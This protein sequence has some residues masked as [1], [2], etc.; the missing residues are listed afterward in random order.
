MTQ[1]KYQTNPSLLKTGEL[2]LVAGQLVTT[3]GTSTVVVGNPA[4]STAVS[5][6]TATFAEEVMDV[7]TVKTLGTG[8][9]FLNG[10]SFDA[11]GSSDYEF[12]EANGTVFG[13]YGRT[14]GM[15]Q[16]IYFAGASNNQQDLQFTTV[17]YVPPF[18]SSSIW[19]AAAVVGN[20][21]FGFTLALRDTTAATL[22]FRF[23]YVRHNGSLINTAGHTYVEITPLVNSYMTTVGIDAGGLPRVTR[24]GAY[25]FIAASSWTQ[26]WLALGGWNAQDATFPFGN[27]A[28]AA[29]AP[30]YA[31][32]TFTVQAVNWPNMATT[33]PALFPK[34]MG[35]A[36]PGQTAVDL[37]RLYDVTNNVLSNSIGGNWPLPPVVQWVDSTPVILDGEVDG[38][39]NPFLAFGSVGQCADANANSA[40]FELVYSLSVSFTAG[41]AGAFT[42]AQFV[43]NTPGS[44]GTD[45]LHCQPF[46]FI[47]S[48]SPD[49][50][51]PNETVASNAAVPSTCVN[52]LP[53]IQHW[54]GNDSAN[55]YNSTRVVNYYYSGFGSV[56]HVGGTSLYRGR[57]QIMTG[58]HLGSAAAAQANKLAHIYPMY[59]VVPRYDFSSAGAL[60]SKA[61]VQP[62]G[63]LTAIEGGMIVAADTIVT[64]GVDTLGN[65]RWVVSKLPTNSTLGDRTYN[66]GGSAVPGMGPRVAEYY[67]NN[68]TLIG[69][70]LNT[71]YNV[72]P[73]GI[74]NIRNPLNAK[75]PALASSS[76]NSPNPNGVTMGIGNWTLSGSTYNEPNTTQWTTSPSMSSQ[77]AAVRATAFT[78]ALAFNAGRFGTLLSCEVVPLLNSAGTGVSMA[79]GVIWVANG[80][81]AAATSLQEFIFTTPCSMVG[82]VI[83]LTNTASVTMFAQATQSGLPGIPGTTP[84]SDSFFGRVHHV[85]IDATN[86]YLLW[87]TANGVSVNG[88]T[89]ACNTIAKLSGTTVTSAQAFITSISRAFF[90]CH[91]QTQGLT[92]FPQNGVTVPELDIPIARYTT[93][94]VNAVADFAAS[95]NQA[96]TTPQQQTNFAE[97]MTLEAINN[98]FLLQ[99]GAVSGR[100]NHKEYNLPSTFID[101]TGFAVGTYFLYLQD[102]G[103]GGVQLVA[104]A[105]QIAESA[106]STYFGTFNRTSGGFSGQTSIAEMTRFG[107]ARLVT[108]TSGVAMQGSQIRVG[109]YVG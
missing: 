28:L 66:R 49:E 14:D 16:Q 6:L 17:P 42:N 44:G 72:Y 45:L 105:S 83:S 109:P 3:D 62:S 68:A 35:N 94:A 56:V 24:V 74:A 99:L 70:T 86:Q 19:Q 11:M 96:L 57:T 102:T 63:I 54:G 51:A 33:S 53:L 26:G 84:T 47:V 103:V 78:A 58:G 15:N 37:F 106:T 67:T 29:S 34:L 69:S 55:G 85:Y 4:N 80:V 87:T 38:S 1:Y 2:G 95:F 25:F 89:W 65:G 32:T 10:T 5:D 40:P 90:N 41:S 13:L 91:P 98:V 82:G 7:S 104:S 48:F 93:S 75:L 88:D 92:W 31:P 64:A 81:G 30:A 52:K 9:V 43:Y 97:L 22:T 60:F 12:E 71:L 79:I 73:V 39:G 100:L 23:I 18:L 20:D 59:N 107:T 50:A 21:L 8:F 76:I 46:P 101:T 77:I 27:A 108:G 61:K 36:V